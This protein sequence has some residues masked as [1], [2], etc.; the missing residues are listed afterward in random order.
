LNFLKKNFDAS[1][2][3]SDISFSM[4]TEVLLILIE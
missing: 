4:D 2:K 3:S 1:R